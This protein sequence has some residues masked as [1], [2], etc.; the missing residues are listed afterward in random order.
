MSDQSKISVFA[1]LHELQG[2]HFLDA[3]KDDRGYKQ[4]VRE[5]INQSDFV[6]EE[7]GGKRPT[8]AEELA[9]DKDKYWDIDSPEQRKKDGTEQTCEEIVAPGD[10]WNFVI[11]RKVLLEK[12]EAVLVQ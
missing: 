9:K 11:L 10:H 7:A 8:Y 1:V 5:L 3:V 2:E 4:Q 12:Q 6:F